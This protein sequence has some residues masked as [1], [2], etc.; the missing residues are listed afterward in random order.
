MLIEAVHNPKPSKKLKPHMLQR[1]LV[2]GSR[3]NHKIAPVPSH[4]L[5]KANMAAPKV[6]EKKSVISKV[7]YQAG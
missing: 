6:E 4:Q 7:V 5:S 2:G 3:T 1:K